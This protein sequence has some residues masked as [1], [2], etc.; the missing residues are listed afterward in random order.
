[1]PTYSEIKKHILLALDVDV[2]AASDNTIDI[3]NQVERELKRVLDTAVQRAR[4]MELFVE[5]AAF[6][7]DD[8]TTEIDLAADLGVTNLDQVFALSVDFKD[9]ADR[10]DYG[11]EEIKYPTWLRMKKYRSGDRRP[12]GTWTMNPSN[13]IILSSWPESSQTWDVYL[14]YY[15]TTAAVSDSGTPELPTMS[16]LA[17]LVPGVCVNFPAR[18]Q[19]DKATQL[20]VFRKA[21][22]DAMADYVRNQKT[23]TESIR[24][25]AAGPG[26]ALNS[27]RWP[28][29]QDT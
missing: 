23:P 4:P 2:E 13:E 16:Q 8:T 7:I 18:F 19:G 24:L 9:T 20:A 5:T 17:I 1:M 21:Y 28:D 26:S 29:W 14:N 27:L 15:K 3:V 12:L 10:D 6:N 22:E 25:Y 11:W